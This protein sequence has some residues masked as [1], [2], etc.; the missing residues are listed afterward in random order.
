MIGRN[1]AAQRLARPHRQLRAAIALD[2]VLQEEIELP[3]ELLDVERDAV[4][5]IRRRRQLRA[6][7]LQRRDQ[8]DRL[9]IERRVRRRRRRAQVRLQRDVAEILQR[10]DAQLVDVIDDLRDR[11]RHRRQQLRDVHERQRGVVERRRVHR[12][13]ERLVRRARGCGS[14]GGRTRRWSA[15]ARAPRAAGRRV[16]IAL[17]ALVGVGRRRGGNGHLCDIGDRQSARSARLRL[18]RARA[19]SRRQCARHGA[20][21]R[22]RCSSERARRAESSRRRSPRSPSTIAPS[23]IVTSSHTIDRVTRADGAICTRLRRR[24]TASVPSAA[25]TSR[26]SARSRRRCRCRG[27]GC[28]RT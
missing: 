24:S 9:A 10:Q 15:R 7:P 21:P 1:S 27:T 19:I 4:G 17:H 26:S 5:Q 12:E 11:H 28:R 20:A 8:R 6:A 3:R 13:H 25:A 16:E 14:S 18:D 2:E 22:W 23:P